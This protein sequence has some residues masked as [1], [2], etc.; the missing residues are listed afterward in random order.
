MLRVA[1]LV[2]CSAGLCSAQDSDS[3]KASSKRAR[4]TPF[5]TSKAKWSI[6]GKARAESRLAEPED[7]R[8]DRYRQNVADLT[9][10]NVF[11]FVAGLERRWTF[12]D[13]Q[14]QRLSILADGFS[15]RIDRCK[16]GETINVP[17]KAGG[18]YMGSQWLGAT[19]A[20]Q[21]R[22]RD[23]TSIGYLRVHW[24]HATHCFKHHVGNRLELWQHKRPWI[25]ATIHVLPHPV[26]AVTDKH[27]RFT[28]P[29][30]PPGQYE[31]VAVHELLGKA[32]QKITIARR[33]PKPVTMLFRVPKKL[34]FEE[35]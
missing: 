34:R 1:V 2:V 17:A 10:P 27:G 15:R 29:K 12:R 26:Y 21:A 33:Q 22:Y 23:A 20:E 6:R 14:K 16:P 11:V 18:F 19:K 32:T 25:R 24:P 35:H 5:P 7:K 30:L 3:A 13:P 28:L 4:P 9:L 31:L 8:D